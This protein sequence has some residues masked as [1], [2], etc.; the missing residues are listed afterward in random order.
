VEK[1]GGCVAHNFIMTRNK[2]GESKLEV[3]TYFSNLVA[4]VPRWAAGVK[5]AQIL[6][7]SKRILVLCCFRG[8]VIDTFFVCVCLSGL[9]SL[10]SD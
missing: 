8:I 6:P 5:G 10:F 1:K 7:F 3:H 9:H 2:A 4:T